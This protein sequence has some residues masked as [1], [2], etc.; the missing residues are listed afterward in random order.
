MFRK[1]GKKFGRCD[2][3]LDRQFIFE[4]SVNGKILRPITDTIILLGKEGLAL[5]GH[6]GDS[7]HDPDVGEFSTGSVGNFN[8]LLDYRVRGGERTYKNALKATIILQR[9]LHIKNN[10]E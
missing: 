9:Y 4:V 10:P 8:E 3:M 5:R 6:R 7:Q 2:E 1:N